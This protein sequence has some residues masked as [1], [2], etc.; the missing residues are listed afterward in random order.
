MALQ[1]CLTTARPKAVHVT[2]TVVFV[3]LSAVVG[4]AIP[5][6]TIVLGYKGAI[7]GSLIVYIFPALMYWTVWADTTARTTQYRELYETNQETSSV[8]S[9]NAE[10]TEANDHDYDRLLSPQADDARSIKSHRSAL[11]VVGGQ[12]RSR[13]GQSSAET[14]SSIAS[15]RMLR[16]SIWTPTGL[17]CL[18]MVLW[19]V[20]MGVMGALSTAGVFKS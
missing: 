18:L 14:H 15:F 12:G 3:F 17:L 6:V 13:V 10:E 9:L 11:S 19:G 2:V 1:P 7:L 8:M 4:I 5:N 20:A 16:R